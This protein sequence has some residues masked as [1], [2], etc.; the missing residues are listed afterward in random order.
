MKRPFEISEEL[1]PFK[2]QWCMVDEIPIHYIDE[3]EGP[4][5]LFL[6]GNYMWSFSWRKAVIELRD[7]FR[8][9]AIDLP[10]MGMSGKP[11]ELGMKHFGYT[12]EEQSDVIEKVLEKLGLRD[13]TFIAYDHGGPIGFGAAIKSPERFS[14]F[15]VTNTWAWLNRYPATTVMSHLVPKV[16]RLLQRL[17][18]KNQLVGFESKKEL[19]KPGV[20]EACI[21]PYKTTRD[22]LPITTLANQ[23]TQAKDYYKHL[24]KSFSKL[25]NKKVEIVWATAGK[26]MLSKVFAE[27]IDE[28][29]YLT[30]WQCTF[31]NA[32][33]KIMERTGYWFL[34]NPPKEFVDSIRSFAT[35]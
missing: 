1:Y 27:N 2:S 8:C 31:P 3:G 28:D 6:H 35:T 30:R 33:T 18:T 20:W 13:I 15:L 9:I 26:G 10:G 12:L 17:V 7:Q 34:S 24:N 25:D 4:V 14:K 16:P 29:K 5:L 23:L 11:H 22:F 19:S 21:A 32:E